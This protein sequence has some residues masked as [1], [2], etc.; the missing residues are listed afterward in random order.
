MSTIGI[1][2]KAERPRAVSR[3]GGRENALCNATRILSPCGAD[4]RMVGE[5]SVM[6]PRILSPR[7][8]LVGKPPQSNKLCF[9]LA[10][11]CFWLAIA[12]SDLQT[13]DELKGSADNAKFMSNYAPRRGVRPATAGNKKN[14]MTMA[15]P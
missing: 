1:D 15:R 14:P 6:E 4:S 7:G 5:R 10:K 2:H 12:F 8:A 11:L 9:S 13:Q 3:I